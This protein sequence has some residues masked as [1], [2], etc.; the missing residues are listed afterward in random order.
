MRSN[1]SAKPA[2]PRAATRAPQRAALVPTPGELIAHCDRHM[3]PPWAVEIADTAH[4]V[5]SI[6]SEAP[7]C[8]ADA[9]GMAAWKELLAACLADVALVGH[10]RGCDQCGVFSDGT[11]RHCPEFDRLAHQHAQ[12]RDQA[13]AKALGQ[14]K[15][16]PAT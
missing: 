7:H 4:L 13:I 9:L 3:E 10:F 6:H 8:Q 11:V 14:Q 12:L 5:A 16:A 1:S 2:T 15:T